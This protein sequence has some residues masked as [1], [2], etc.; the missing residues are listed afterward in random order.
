MSSGPSNEET[1]P[2]PTSPGPVKGVFQAPGSVGT[3]KLLRE[4]GRGGMGIVYLGHDRLLER[5][6]AVKFLLNLSGDGGDPNFTGLLEGA[7]MAAAV[8]HPGLTT[9]HQAALFGRMPYLVMEYIDGPTLR[10]VLRRAGPLEPAI[11]CAVCATVATAVA[12]LHEQAVV[13]RD[14]KP[15]NVLLD[16]AGRVFVSDFGLACR[17]AW[18]EAGSSGLG[19]CGT[20][21][22]MAPEMFE[23]DVSA[24]T[25]VYALGVTSFELL[26]GAHPFAGTSAEVCTEQCERPLPVELLAE[27]GVPGP[28]IEVVERA[29]H[30]NPLFRYR[31]AT[32]FQRALERVAPTFEARTLGPALAD[33]GARCRRDDRDR[34]DAAVAATPSSSYYEHLA[35]TAARKRSEKTRRPGAEANPV[36][37]PAPNVETAPAAAPDTIVVDLPCAGCTYNLRGLS[38]SGRCPECGKPIQASVAP[39]R[40]LFADRDWLRRLRSGLRLAHF[41]LIGSWPWLI[42]A[43]PVLV[44]SLMSALFFLVGSLMR[45]KQGRIWVVMVFWAVA[46]VL[47]GIHVVGVW[48]AAS[49][50]PQHASGSANRVRRLSRILVWFVPLVAL[51]VPA[52]A[53]VDDFLGAAS[54]GLGLAVMLVALGW[55][56]CVLMSSLLVY[57]AF[58]A[59]QM[60]DQRLRGRTILVVG[61]LG[62]V[63][64]ASFVAGLL[65]GGVWGAALALAIGCMLNSLLYLRVL[66]SYSRALKPIVANCVPYGALLRSGPPGPAE[67]MDDSETLAHSREAMQENGQ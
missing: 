12:A 58:L 47:L 29:T 56:A 61:I 57:L 52:G 55:S 62:A 27:R 35:Q 59:A 54:A 10:D 45:M 26:H 15:S 36:S 53:V 5:D 20:P 22:Y 13:H 2:S 31:S 9:I 51:A 65:G 63:A 41:G 38:V 1:L 66:G 46:L 67:Q 48:R 43:L 40:L 11:G 17:R 23:G 4:I 34:S 49:A 28:V 37:T 18:H 21:A 64:T 25:D 8:R 39:E 7:R 19:V 32:Q 30:K 3:V 44:G 33:L 42:Y 24:R 50:R 60:P 6:V 14:I 16:Q